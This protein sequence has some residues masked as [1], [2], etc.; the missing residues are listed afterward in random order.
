[1]AEKGVIVCATI[2]F[3]MG[4]DKPDVR[5]VFHADL[6]SS[7]DA[8]YQE[9]GRGG[10]DGQEAEAHMVF[11]LSDIVM[12]R[13]FIN[14]GD[15]GDKH[16]CREKGLLCQSRMGF[17]YLIHR[18][19]RTYFLEDQI[20]RYPRAGKNRLTTETVSTGGDQRVGKRSMNFVL[21]LFSLP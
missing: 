13:K 10:R 7:L 3:G 2:A 21:H 18:F 6:P 11:G 15:A 9:I 1:M 12:R 8:Y 14:E 20:N 5:F 4:I 17:E 16:K 19:T